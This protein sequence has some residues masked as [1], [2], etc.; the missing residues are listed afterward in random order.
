MIFAKYAIFRPLV[1]GGGL[2]TAN[3]FKN[4]KIIKRVVPGLVPGPPGM[5]VIRPEE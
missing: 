4:K 5:K 3:I 1:S 2:R